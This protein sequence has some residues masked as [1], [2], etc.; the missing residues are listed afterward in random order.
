MS[1]SSRV[2]FLVGQPCSGEQ[3]HTIDYMGNSNWIPWVIKKKKHMKVGG[4]GVVRSGVD[5]G[6]FRGKDRCL[7]EI[8][9]W[10]RIEYNSGLFI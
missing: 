8:P 9:H 6:E 3:A 1:V 4:V 5:L 10:L 2:W 7:K